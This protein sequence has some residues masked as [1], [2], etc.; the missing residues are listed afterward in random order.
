MRHFSIRNKLFVA[1]SLLG[2]I[3]LSTGFFFVYNNA[4]KSLQTSIKGQLQTSTTLITNLVQSVASSSIENHLK[5]IA[6][7][8]L[9][10]VTS[11]YEEHL[12]G[13]LSESEAKQIA[14]KTLGKQVI[15]TSGYFY[16]IDSQGNVPVHRDKNV[17]N[18]NLL[19]F[20]FVQDQVRLKTGYI[21]YRW[22]NSGEEDAREKALYMVYFEPWDWIIS[23]STYK[24]EF[25]NLI[26]LENLGKALDKI[27]FA[28]HGYPFIFGTNGDVIY[29]PLLS[30]NLYELGLD[31]EAVLSGKKILQQKKGTVYYSWK[32]SNESEVRKK[33]SILE[34]LPEYDWVVGSSAYLDELHHPLE[35]MQQ[36]FLLIFLL[37]GLLLLSA[38]FGLSTL[39]TNPLKK[40][41]THFKDKTATD[42]ILITDRFSSD[43][44]G[45]L[46]GYLNQFIEKLNEHHVQ[47]E[48]EINERE[49]SERTFHTLFDHS[50][51]F[52]ALLDPDGY[53]CKINKTALSF[54]NLKEADVFGELFWETPWWRHSTTLVAQLKEAFSEAREGV[55]SRFEGYSNEVREVYLDISLKP[56][57]DENK[58]VIYIIAEAR[59][60]TELRR[61]ERELQQVQKMESVGTLAGGI[62][63]D[64][65]NILGGI[66]GTVDLLKLKREMNGSVSDEDLIK[67]LNTIDDTALRAKG[68]VN[69]LLTLSRK[70][71]LNVVSFD[72]FE[73]LNNVSQI[74]R[75]S[76][77]KSVTIKTDFDDGISVKGDANSLEQVFLNVCINAAHSMTIMRGESDPWGGVLSIRVDKVIGFEQPGYNIGDY[78]QISIADSGIGMDHSVVEQIFTPFY[79]TKD[80]EVGTGL[81]LSMVF[82]IIRQHHGFINVEST[83]GAGSSFK[84]YLPV[85]DDVVTNGRIRPG[86]ELESGEGLILIIDDEELIR[87]NASEILQA[88]GYKILKAENGLQGIE[89]Y[90]HHQHDICAV[91][92]DLVMP[93][94]SG[95]EAFTELKIINPE[96]KVL[97]SSGFRHDARVDEILNAGADGYIQKPYSLFDLSKAIK[98]LLSD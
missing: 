7:T 91:L 8:Q 71:D 17:V 62:A 76:F 92:L 22:K 34:F 63:H 36:V 79:T 19:S 25:S 16:C 72:L 94:M 59:E 44:V 64:F 86:K 26:D 38:S 24:S 80:K 78:W 85:C 95:K 96:V 42:V 27:K 55:V 9:L 3:A 23:A 40:L 68:I 35:R 73:V 48:S 37:Y 50:F 49:R 56:V 90:Q 74:G 20:P 13:R 77:D 89:L 60:I 28:E 97:L 54:R 88:C 4:K 10:L 43:E 53:V 11:M 70:Y 29:H 2:L 45:T 1:F 51:Q 69:Q 52:I 57:L 75:N 33:I 6:E 47:L 5:A 82:N 61:T 66:L 83:V 31:S 18:S 46:A 30:G 98:N 58:Q 32:N 65:N 87:N 39:V 84:I 67:S 12:N 81:G 21:E 93:V 15:G 14:A 41:I